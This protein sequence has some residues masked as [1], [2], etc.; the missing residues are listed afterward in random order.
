MKDSP[1]PMKPTKRDYQLFNRRM[2]IDVMMS[3]I[4]HAA[5]KSNLPC[6]WYDWKQKREQADR[7]KAKIG[8]G[9]VNRVRRW[10]EVLEE[11][12]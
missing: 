4:Y 10:A 3:Y 7:M 9:P 12:E 5:R 1:T 2:K 6:D 8:W 11:T